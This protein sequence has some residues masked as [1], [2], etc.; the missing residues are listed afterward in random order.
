[1]LAS[2]PAFAGMK[3]LLEGGA[4]GRVEDVDAAVNLS[5][6]VRRRSGWRY[7]RKQ[8]GGG[9]VIEIASHL[10]AVLE[11][12]LGPP[13][14]VSAVTR[15]AGEWSEDEA[16]I[17]LIYPA[18]GPRVRV[19]CSRT[20]PGYPLL[21]VE[22]TLHGEGGV[23]RV[24]GEDLLRGA[25][26]SDLR[27]VDRRE[28]PAEPSFDLGGEAFF[29]HDLAF[30]RKAADPSAPFPMSWARGASV[31]AIVDAV[32]RSAAAGAEAEVSPENDPALAPERTA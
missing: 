7:D 32:Y 18:G 1:M 3:R 12:L 10:L 29:L 6:V 2:R 16:D 22:V 5:E 27:P 14:S 21:E 26:E 24:A 4:V 11:W 13:A 9:V 15:P 8:A 31:Q 19:A 28:L 17:R 23:L 20:R 30:L 25:S